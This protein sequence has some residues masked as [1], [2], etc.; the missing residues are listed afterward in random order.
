MGAY[1]A[2]L[3]MLNS[4]GGIASG[5]SYPV[6][7][8]FHVPHG[9]AG[10]I[11]LPYV[12]DF[13][14]TRGYRGYEV[15]NPEMGSNTTFSQQIEELYEILNVP[16]NLSEWGAT[17]EPAKKIL[18]ELTLSQRSGSFSY[19]PTP[20]DEVDLDSLLHLLCQAD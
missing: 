14:T 20:F 7:T 18:K 6:G 8:Q 1:L 13:N 10:G 12:I 3:A 11:I 5:V 9:F 16:R 2:G 15:L 17:G 4:S 19:N